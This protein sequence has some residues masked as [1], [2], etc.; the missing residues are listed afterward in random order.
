M[1]RIVLLIAGFILVSFSSF[2]LA[3]YPV[4]TGVSITGG[5]ATLT[6]ANSGINAGTA[7]I[8]YGADRY[9]IDV[10]FS[11]S[12]SNILTG[13]YWAWNA[14]SD[15]RWSTTVV[16]TG[17][18]ITVTG[19]C[20]TFSVTRNIY[21]NGDKFAM[22]DSIQNKTT[23]N[24]AVETYYWTIM[25]AMVTT[26]KS[27]VAGVP[28]QYNNAY[29]HQVTGCGPNP[30][31]FMQQA[32]SSLGFLV[33]DD[34]Y[35]QAMFLTQSQDGNQ[36]GDTAYNVTTMV[37]QCF[38]LAG[39]AGYTFRFS[40]YPGGAGHDY[41]KFINT[42]RN[43]W[44]VNYTLYGPCTLD[45][46]LDEGGR[47]FNWI[48]LNPWFDFLEGAGVS[49]N[50]YASDE[51]T[52][53]NMAMNTINTASSTDPVSL[54]KTPTFMCKIETDSMPVN[55]TTFTNGNTLP[56]GSTSHYWLQPLTAAQ[57][58]TL[59]NNS[60]YAHQ[61][62]D[63]VLWSST[64]KTTQIIETAYIDPGDLSPSPGPTD[65]NKAHWFDLVVYPGAKPSTWAVNGTNWQNYALTDFNFQTQYIK[66]QI[67]W[68]LN[69]C[70][71]N[72]PANCG[73]AVYIDSF[74][75][76]TDFVD[77]A[78]SYSGLY[79]TQRWD[80]GQWDGNSILMNT[81]TGL[82]TQ[83]LTD[84]TL[85]GIPARAY[86]LNYMLNTKG[87]GVMTNGHPVD[88]ETRSFHSQNY[89]ETQGDAVGTIAQLQALV[90]GNEPAPSATM[91]AG[92]LSCPV[93]FSMYMG[94]S[95]Y[96]ESGS[97]VGYVTNNYAEI[98]NKY[99]IMCLRNGS[100]MAP[101]DN[102]VPSTGT[103]SGG[104]GIINL[105]YPIT[106]VELHE[107]YMIGKEKIVT[108][109]SGTFYWNK[110]DHPMKPSVCK[111]FDVYGNANTPKGFSVSS[112]GAQWV[113]K[114][115]LQSDWNGTAMVY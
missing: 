21:W 38:G 20:P 76:T 77:N 17:S 97:T 60:T 26:N 66:S 54:C 28:F 11:E 104:Y 22:N 90:N 79:W 50:Q 70:L 103:G 4:Q 18:T 43:D 13:H 64:T 53:V 5:G 33:E 81:S 61:W 8:D 115:K 96:T 108:A 113:V 85:V 67:D 69:N 3:S 16:K 24:I 65:T 73:K 15:S 101:T 94:D 112:I 102:Y 49:W 105:M 32:N 30:T 42:V 40:L 95:Y 31:I 19:S 88:A 51:W 63:S 56:N 74:T 37:N 86:L 109:V 2:A 83:L 62:A 6:V 78:S 99:L 44:N 100:L 27:C 89:E 23:A 14:G 110:K 98:Q 57:T 10:A 35:R 7:E 52:Y 9:L 25:A 93:S 75:L 92:Q 68:T 71:T 111:T 1:R 107:G 59:Q 58:S 55:T 106:P 72:V 47:E 36:P 48:V 45:Q 34:F 82:I 12:V 29:T 80:G 41:W 39:N 84:C 114:L 87:V 91:A 46:H